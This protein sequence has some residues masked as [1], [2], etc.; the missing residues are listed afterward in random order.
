MLLNLTY[1]SG[2]EIFRVLNDCIVGK[3]KLNWASCKGIKTDGAANM[4][5]KNSGVVTKISEAA[6]N[7][8]TWKHCFIHR[9]ALAA[10]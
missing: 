2:S 4:T 5:G 8:I 3:H 1:T 6:G 7:D 9:E 10:N